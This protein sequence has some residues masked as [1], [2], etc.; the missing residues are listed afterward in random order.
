MTRAPRK[1]AG[2]RPALG[3]GRGRDGSMLRAR[4]DRRDKDLVSAYCRRHGVTEGELVREA[5][6]VAGVLKRRPNIDIDPSLRHPGG[7]G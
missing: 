5:L 6:I 7:E 3:P 2:G 1:H 4:V